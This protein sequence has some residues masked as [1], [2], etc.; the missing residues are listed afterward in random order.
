MNRKTTPLILT[1]V[2][3][4]LFSSCGSAATPSSPQTPASETAQE[5]GSQS[6][7]ITIAAGRSFWQG[8]TSH[9]Y[10]HGSTN[11]WEPL[12]MIDNSMNP[13]M[14]LADDIRVSEDGLTWTITLKEQV[15][16]RDG[17]ALTSEVA[18]F[19]LDRLYHFNPAAKAY[20]PGYE[21]SSEY[22]EIVEMK[23][24]DDLTLTVTH[25]SAIPDFD[26]LL[27][28]EGSAMFALASFD[29]S[30]TIQHPIGTGPYQ[31][32]S[33]DES[34]QTLILS[35]FDGYRLGVPK[36]DAVKFQNIPDATARLAAL[37][38]GSVDV[39]SDV[40]GIL[41]QQADEVLADSNLVLAQQQVSTV[42]YL[43]MN[44]N[45]GKLFHSRD[46]RNALSM[47]VDRQTVVDSLL[48]GYGREA[49][50]VL[51]DLSSRWTIDCG[52]TFDPDAAKTLKE[53]AV[54]PELQNAVIVIS[55]AL[56]GRWPYQDVA[57]L[58]QAQL[59]AIG[60]EAVIETVDAATWS[61]RLKDGDYDISIHP[62][63]VSAGEPNFF[64]TRNLKTGGSNNVSRG[65]G[66]S[67]RSLDS[68]IEAVATEPAME[69]RQEYYKQMQ[70]LAKT[71]DYIIP[72]WYDVTLYAMNKRVQNFEIDV[73]FCP[74]MFAVDVAE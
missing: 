35:R 73:I 37:R 13:T 51:T 38:S 40:G 48:F 16:F 5:T 25:A 63:T 29:D 59:D 20:D 2:L 56:T 3:V 32:E 58:L 68:L 44:T 52:Y 43:C 6:K 54:G 57:L 14:Q 11:V 24:V 47:S 19:N 41:P 4:L 74:N 64:F 62:F 18:V 9:I 67:D 50:S 55:S 27:A 28:Y 17:S 46:L 39:I 30:K 60:V 10:L 70:E 33:Y 1:L 45:E 36:L 65:Y 42:H 71:E 49:V 61:Q 26:L 23:A 34:Q 53:A 66:I 21:K 72:I 15:L 8:P 12:V 22:G 69:K 7:S 31:Y